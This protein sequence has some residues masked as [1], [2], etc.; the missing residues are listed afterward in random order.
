MISSETSDL[1]LF[2]A[3]DALLPGV[4]CRLRT[5]VEVEFF[6]YVPDVCFNGTLSNDQSLRNL[7]I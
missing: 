3:Y 7:S 2:P 1:Y 5:V 6:E 4:D